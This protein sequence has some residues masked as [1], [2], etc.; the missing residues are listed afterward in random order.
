MGS[1]SGTGGAK[2]P[3]FGRHVEE[4]EGCGGAIVEVD[5]PRV[6]VVDD[7]TVEDVEVDDNFFDEPE[8]A[9]TATSNEKKPTNA[10]KNKPTFFALIDPSS[11]ST[12]RSKLNS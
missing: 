4:P 7:V 2:P 12:I 6:V 10:A 8:H 11:R 3:E 9:L 5:D 1:G